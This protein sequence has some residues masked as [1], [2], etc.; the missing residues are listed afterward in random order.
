M[1]VGVVRIARGAVV[2][3]LAGEVVGVLAH[4]ERA[5]QHGAGRLQPRDQR[6]VGRRP[7]ARSRLILEPASVGR[8]ATSN[9]FLT[10]N[11]TPAS[12]PSGLPRARGRIDRR[13]PWRARARASTAVKAL[14]SRVALGDA[15]QRRLDDADGAGPCRRRRPRR[16]R[17][18][19]PTHPI[20][21]GL[22]HRR[23]LGLVRQ[24]ELGHDTPQARSVTCRLALMAGFHS[25]SI[26]SPVRS[27]G[28][29]QLSRAGSV[30]S[31]LRLRTVIRLYAREAWSDELHPTLVD[32]WR[33]PNL[34]STLLTRSRA[35]SHRRMRD[36][37]QQL[38]RVV[39]FRREQHALRSAP[40]RRSG[41]ARMT[42]TRSHSSRTTF[43]SCETNR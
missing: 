12:G 35:A 3:V 34:A 8:P 39:R 19:S 23:R 28:V 7:A 18:L 27:A 16:S 40:A 33:S 30:F 5:D 14:S 1:R 15:R 32:A 10:A 38:A 36:G 43:R 17:P 21:S 22:E 6:R 2:H 20:G 4:V 13:A 26:G 29:D 31:S 9:R 25:A 42:I 37:G 41:P 11:G 24:L